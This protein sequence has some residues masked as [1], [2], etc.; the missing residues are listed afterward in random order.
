MSVGWTPLRAYRGTRAHHRAAEDE[1]HNRE[2]YGGDGGPGQNGG[3]EAI[4]HVC[5][6]TITDVR[7]IQH[8]QISTLADRCRDRV[9]QM[10][11]MIVTRRLPLPGEYPSPQDNR[12][13]GCKP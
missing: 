4:R 5:R 3:G 7:V 9:R 2:R 11:R 6:R 1:R 10:R 12:H 13:H 8:H